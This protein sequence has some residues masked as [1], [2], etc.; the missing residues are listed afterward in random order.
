MRHRNAATEARAHERA[1]HGAAAQHGD[2]AARARADR[3]HRRQG[4]GAAARRG[5][6]DHA[7]QA[8]RPARAPPGAARDPRPRG[9]EQGLRRAGRA[10]RGAPGRLHAGAEDRATRVGDA[11]PMSIIELVDREVEGREGQAPAKPAKAEKKA[12]SKAAKKAAGR[13]SPRRRRAGKKAGR[14]R[15]A[16]TR[17]GGLRASRPL[18]AERWL[19]PR[20]ARALRSGWPP[21]RSRCSWPCCSRSRA[22]DPIR[23]GPARAGLRAAAA[24]RATRRSRSTSLRGRVVLLNFWATWC[25][26]CEDGDAGDA[27]P[28]HGARGTGLRAARDLGGRRPTTR[29]SPFRERLALTFPIRSTR[30]SGSR[31]QY[32]SFRFPESLLIDRD[33][34]IVA[35]YIGPRDWDAPAYVERIRRAGRGRRAAAAPE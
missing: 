18:G 1:P 3:D 14:R 5:P 8:R 24:R 4:Q 31:S 10:L 12:A 13:R 29:S 33:G 7:R 9:R 32:Q 34:R 26:P 21:S 25:K 16:T 35:R 19:A 30:R 11:A 28:P 20:V 22:P 23:R 6:D 27:A 15:G 17:S 2:V